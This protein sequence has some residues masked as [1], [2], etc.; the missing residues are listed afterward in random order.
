LYRAIVDLSVHQLLQKQL[1]AI[2]SHPT[3]EIKTFSTGSTLKLS[4]EQRVG[5]EGPE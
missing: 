2:T 5:T 1:T 3:A 4:R